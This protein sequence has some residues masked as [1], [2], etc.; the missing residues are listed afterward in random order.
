MRRIRYEGIESMFP[1]AQRVPS[2]I[3]WILGLTMLVGCI[4]PGDPAYYGLGPFRLY[5]LEKEQQSDLVIGPMGGLLPDDGRPALAIRIDNK[6]SDT[7]WIR[8]VVDAAETD[9]DW[10][11]VEKLEPG[12]GSMMQIRRQAVRS[13]T[14]YPVSFSLYSDSELTNL[15]EEI[16]TQFR[17]SSKDLQDFE[18]LTGISASN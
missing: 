10:N 4:S 13:D 5:P 12:R 6:S 7:L 11:Q 14:A 15:K 2:S 9:P 16:R 3:I 1:I 18:R 8:I 17:F